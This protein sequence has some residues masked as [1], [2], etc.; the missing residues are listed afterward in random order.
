MPPKQ[1]KQ[2]LLASALA[3]S[4]LGVHFYI[5]FARK[6]IRES[7]AYADPDQKRE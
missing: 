1:A 5:D 6:K 3:F 7:V 2:V 4:V